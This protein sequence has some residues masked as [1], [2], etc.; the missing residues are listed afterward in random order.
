MADRGFTI[1]Q[2]LDE[3]EAKLIIPP[4]MKGKDS[5]NLGEEYQTRE[6][7]SARVHIERWNQRFKTFEFMKGPIPQQK[8]PI[9]NEAAYVCAILANF[10][11]VL[12]K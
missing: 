10:S 12:V 4:F 5:L 6:I 2:L 9:F 7:A 1:Q 11:P 3:K 8:M